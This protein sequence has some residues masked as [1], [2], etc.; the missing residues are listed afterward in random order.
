MTYSWLACTDEIS[1]VETRSARKRFSAELKMDAR[2]PPQ[3]LHNISVSVHDLSELK[4]LY[5]K[6]SNSSVRSKKKKILHFVIGKNQNGPLLWFYFKRDTN[7]ITNL[8][9]DL[10][11]NLVRRIHLCNVEAR[12][13]TCLENWIRVWAWPIHVYTEQ[14]LQNWRH[15]Y[16]LLTFYLV[17]Q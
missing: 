13:E 7:C 14:N 11:R 3:F 10:L 9:M 5:S 8:L 17:I 1:A 4:I 6:P 12:A 2:W 16:R 15:S